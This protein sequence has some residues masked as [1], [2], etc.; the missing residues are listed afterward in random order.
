VDDLVGRLIGERYRIEQLLGAGDRKRTYLARDTRVQDRL[1]ALSIVKPEAIALDPGGTQREADVLGRIGPHANIVAFHD[2]ANDGS[3][4]YM[5]FQYL[6]GGTL[7]D[8]VA[9]R[10]AQGE[11][12]SNEQVLRF[13]R[14]L[15]RA[16]SHIHAKGL[17]HR[18]V[19]PT[20]YGSMS[21]MRLTSATSTPRSSPG[22]MRGSAR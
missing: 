17:L 6:S 11:G 5:V 7:A 8:Y 12:L 16:L 1:V 9:R 2:A 13:S 10:N 4:Q 14:Q 22:Q 3:L 20:T 18:D 21:A 15:G 19:S